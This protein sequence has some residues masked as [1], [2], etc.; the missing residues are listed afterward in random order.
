L[1]DI[2]AERLLVHFER[3]D[4]G[5]D[6]LPVLSLDNTSLAGIS[7]EN[8]LLKR[9]GLF[10]PRSVSRSDTLVFCAASTVSDFLLPRRRHSPARLTLT[11]KSIS[12]HGL[13]N[14]CAHK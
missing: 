12:A 1:Q 6:D 10:V 14:K 5:L 9:L 11:L 8:G 7:G 13:L 4:F 2:I 3:I